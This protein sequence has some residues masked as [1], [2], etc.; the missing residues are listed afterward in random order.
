MDQNVRNGARRRSGHQDSFATPIRRRSSKKSSSSDRH[1]KIYVEGFREKTIRTVTPDGSSPS[2]ERDGRS[3]SERA[4]L[5]STSTPDSV[6]RSNEFVKSSGTSSYADPLRHQPGGERGGRLIDEHNSDS[7]P[8]SVVAKARQRLGS[9]TSSSV[10]KPVNDSS[11]I[12]YPSIMQAAS[13]QPTP[14]RQKLVKSP[15]HPLSPTS[16]QRGDGTRDR[17]PLSPVNSD[18]SKILQLMNVTCG[19][20]NGILFFR[21]PES[22]D[23]SSGYCAINVASGSLIYQEQR[24][25][26]PSNR[27]LIPDL[28]GCN[29]QTRVDEGTQQQYLSVSA[30]SSRLTIQIRPSVPETLNSWLAA[31]L[32]WQ[33]LAPK[34]AQGK[35]PKPQP[36][37]LSHRTRD[38]RRAS[39]GTV[40]KM[41][42]IKVGKLQLWEG[43]HHC[44]SK[45]QSNVPSSSP[46]RALRS[47]WRRVSFILHENGQFKLLDESGG[48]P[49]FTINLPTLSR[50]AVQQL[51]PSVLDAEYTFAVYYQ[52]TAHPSSETPAKSVFF[53]LDSRVSYEVLFVLLRGFATPV[54]Y[55]TLPRSLVPEMDSNHESL[56]LNKAKAE[57]FRVERQLDMRVTEGKLQSSALNK[58]Q[59]S[60]RSKMSQSVPGDTY[61]EIL[62]DGEVRARTAI[63]TGQPFWREE[64]IF[65]DVPPSLSRVSVLI[66]SRDPS[67]KEWTMIARDSSA[68]TLQEGDPFPV[69]GDI[70]VSSH[71][72]AF[73]EVTVQLDD[74]VRGEEVERWWQISDS[75][76]QKCGELFMKIRLN[77][78]IV[79]MSEDYAPLLDLLKTFSNGLT[80]QIAQALPTETKRIS[81]VLLNIYQV[82][83]ESLDWLRALIEDEID[84]I[85]RG[86]ASQR[87]R[88]VNRI[89][90]QES[91]DSASERELL[92]R[93]V[94]RTATLEANL[95]FRGNSLLTF[96]LDAHCRRLGKD[97]LEETLGPKLREIDETQPNCE[98][99]PNRVENPQ[100]L[101]RNWQTL[102]SLT[103]NIWEAILVSTRATR[104][105]VPR[106][107]LIFWQASP[108][109][110]PPE[111]RLLFRHIRS[112]AE[113]RYGDWIRTV[114]Y[115][116]VSGFL[117]LRF[118]CPA[119][120]NPKLFGLM[121]GTTNF[122]MA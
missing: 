3:S 47:S 86:D 98:V 43:W 99:D 54:L 46:Q 59:L 39:E 45:L 85:D 33:P 38:G 42:I 40:G 73:G 26:T 92:V 36:S 100:E 56:Q 32:C 11:S 8:N 89:H 5:R 84:G 102:F 96:A 111:M 93:E 82:S 52:Y 60:S 88:Y 121:K 97:Y 65:N 23:W 116:S 31:L 12:G 41:A 57:M 107:I 78:T 16:L 76:G 109:R 117:F 29:V 50:S 95:L 108:A 79:L 6:R 83:G 62:L 70:E 91:Y 103:A 15:P 19:R 28:R 72:R 14:S 37:T 81:E 112:C 68:L 58:D 105:P 74:L 87:L 94:G 25:S 71:D 64:F 114:S 77:E 30:A 113:D 48:Q 20:M 27:T 51:D 53:G 63:K 66:R 1:G 55:S 21:T 17:A 110:C 90:S 22:S 44:E 119:I 75:R 10:S 118:F 61:A 122:K 34:G 101:E 7:S 104:K 18:H 24:K 67:E 35:L 13:T 2:S 106:P 49:L 115:S 120:L 80:V 69:D 4:P 9:I